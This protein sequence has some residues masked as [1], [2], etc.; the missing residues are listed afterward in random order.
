[1]RAGGTRIGS[2]CGGDVLLAVGLFGIGVVTR[3]FSFFFYLLFEH[4]L[5]LTNF[6]FCLVFIKI[7]MIVVVMVEF[8][9]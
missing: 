1:M 9:A 5:L 6:A 4:F 2:E 8:A 7:H 3:S